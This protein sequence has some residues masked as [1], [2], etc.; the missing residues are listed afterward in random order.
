MT[1]L[2]KGRENSRY[3]NRLARLGAI[4][5]MELVNMSK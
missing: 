4:R 3:S 5:R 1:M 2:L